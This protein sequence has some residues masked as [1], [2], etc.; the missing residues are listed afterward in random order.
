[1]GA[2][3]INFL[4]KGIALSFYLILFL[5]P[6]AV[7]PTTFE[8]FEFNKMWVVFILTILV[9][10]LWITK[11]ILSDK[12]VLKRTPLDIPILAFVLSQIF[13][14][15]FSMDPYVSFWGYYSR[16][17]GGLLSILS[18]A[19]LYFAFTNNLSDLQTSEKKISYKVILVS[20]ITGI[21]VALWGLPSRFGHDP[22]C[23]IFRGSFD[24]SCW[25]DSF[26]PKI[27][28]FSTLGQPNWLA[29]YLSILIPITFSVFLI[30]TFKKNDATQNFPIKKQNSSQSYKSYLQ[31]NNKLNIFNRSLIVKFSLFLLTALFY[32]DLI[33]ANSQ[34]GFLALWVG[35]LSFVLLYI[36]IK[37]KRDKFSFLKLLKEKSFLLLTAVVFSFLVISFFVGQPV[38]SLNKFTFRELKSKVIEPKKTETVPIPAS[39][40]AAPP[41]EQ[42]GG[43]DSSKIRLIVWRG[44]LDIFKNNPVFGS[45]VETFAYAYYKYRPREHNLTSEWDYL[46]NKAHNEYLN[47]LATTGIA[48]ILSYLSII[49]VFIYTALKS[50]LDKSETDEKKILGI[51]ILAAFVSILV[52][53]FFGFSVVI[54]NIYLLLLPAIF[55]DLLGKIR[56]PSM[57]TSNKALQNNQL[58]PE[59]SNPIKMVLVIFIGV[60]CLYF[61]FLLVRFWQADQSYALGYNYNKIGE[62]T[63]AL[64]PLMTATRQ[65]PEEDLYKD[66]LSV[67]L[68]TLALLSSQQNQS[69]Q[70]G[71]LMREAK[72]LSDEVI[73]NH[74]NNVVYYKS[75]TRAMYALSQIDKSYFQDALHAIT[76]ASILAPTDVK[77]SYNMAILYAQ[78]GN[79][80]KAIEVLNQTVKLKPEHRDSH[81][82]LALFYIQLAK[83]QEK[84]DYASAEELKNRARE[85][86]TYIL[87]KISK[88]DMSAKALLE[89]IK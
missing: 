36:L 22:T 40:Q 52:S 31:E 49:F 75:M 84:P 9:A 80:D 26:Q 38:P 11:I 86:I 37:I 29:A 41:V 64:D 60:V 45:G 25:T 35:I 19:F 63:Q 28:M 27:R 87:Q 33:Y 54:L 72:R 32:L 21:V 34:S 89:S 68:A 50:L 39:K 70:A 81:Y 74:P 71:N 8:L 53:N 67:N 13:S 15:I 3:A 73:S 78:D 58:K 42:L 12:L 61:E 83:E 20:L 48:G 2:K 47:Y 5:V 23:L 57:K 69:T 51:G 59:E 77:I 62:Y 44:A 79:V 17:N 1:M 24:V 66:E 82:A 76:K 7:Y 30:K 16:F 18:F 6:L 85:Q 56:L 43:T 10:F 55:Y 4:D 14:T 65:R 88:D 46:Y